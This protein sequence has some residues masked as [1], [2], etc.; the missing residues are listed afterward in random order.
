MPDETRAGINLF[1][2]IMGSPFGFGFLLAWVLRGR[3][4]ALGWAGAFVPKF[5]REWFG[6]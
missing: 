2:C 1:L 4:D 3:V 6:W 5:I